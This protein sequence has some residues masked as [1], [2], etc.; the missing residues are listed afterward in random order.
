MREVSTL[1]DVVAFS[2]GGRAVGPGSPCLLVA[3]VAQAHDGSLGTAHA[4]ID[5][6]AN[7]GADAVKFQSH[8]AA[9]ESTPGEPFR[10]RFSPQDETR[11]DYWRRME[12]SEPQWRALAA[13]AHERGLVFLSSPF[14]LEAVEMLEHVGMPAWKVGAGEITNLPLLKRVAS[15]GHPVL[16][17]SGMSGWEDLDAAVA[18][19][20]AGGAPVAVYQCTSAYP[21]P[22][23]ELGLNLLAELRARYRCPVGLSDHSGTIHAGL[24]AATL[25]AHLLEVH[26]TFSRE[27]FGPDVPASITT[28]ELRGLVQGVRFIER[29][30]ASPVD[31]EAMAR[32][33]SPM[34]A[35][36]GKSL[37]AAR[38]LPAGHRLGE[39]DLRF[40]KPGTGIPAARAA[41]VI[42]R[43]LRRPVPADHLFAETDLE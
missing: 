21:C 11:Y 25:G 18:C 27:C 33:L 10:V 17:S 37:V 39:E 2:I 23:E 6:V 31:K 13:H 40:K 16:L 34:R 3:E 30:L 15:T 32:R 7:A 5:A 35:L 12:F 38:G 14:S 42:G 28:A 22:P 4:Y 20:R 9:A 19:V 43:V 1:A 36:F 29:A 26:V 41:A 8:I 24:A